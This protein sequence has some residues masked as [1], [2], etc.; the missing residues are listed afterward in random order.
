MMRNIAG[1]GLVHPL[2][3]RGFLSYT[4]NPCRVIVYCTLLS[5]AT[6]LNRIHILL[7]RKIDES[8]TQELDRA[9]LLS[10][11]GRFTGSASSISYR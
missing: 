4:V 9:E 3:R 2:K 7:E 11:L 10:S 5:W 6:G 8:R 1:F